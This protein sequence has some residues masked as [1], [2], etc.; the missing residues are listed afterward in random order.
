MHKLSFYVPETHLESVK[1][2]LF[3]VGAGR[4]G[5]YDCCC[6]QAKGTGQYRPL[7]GS[8]PFKGITN[9]IET[10]PEYLVEMVCEDS[11]VEVVI[12]TLYASHPYETPAFSIWPVRGAH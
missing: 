11:I 4:I 5:N 6:W 7:L 12:E 1:T 3:D 2:A 9:K 10:E 8:K